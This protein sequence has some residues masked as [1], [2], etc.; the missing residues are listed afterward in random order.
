MSSTRA[1]AF[2]SSQCLSILG[3][4]LSG[5]AIPWLLLEQDPSAA[6]ASMVLSFQ[7]LAALMTMFVGSLL[8]DR[9]DKRRFCMFSDATLSLA[10]AII[11]G[12]YVAKLLTPLAIVFFVVLHAV[13]RSLAH[14]AET[15]LIPQ[16]ASTSG[17]SNHRINGLIGVFHN[18][19]DLLGPAL[20]GLIIT[21]IGL[22]GALALDSA[23][24]LISLLLF[25][26]CIPASKLASPIAENP[27]TPENLQSQLFGGIKQIL[28][29]PLLRCVTIASAIINM[30]LT[31]LLSVLILVLVKTRSGS[32]LDAGLLLSCF[33]IGGFIASALFAWAGAK[34]APLPAMAA[35]LILMLAA[36]FTLPLLPAHFVLPCLFVIGLCV[37]YLGPL[38]Q[39]MVQNHTQEALLGRVL[40]AYSAA[41]TVFVPVGF[42]LTAALLPHY[43]VQ[44]VCWAMAALLLYPALNVVWFV[45]GKREK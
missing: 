15:A 14:A 21:S 27:P 9:F 18:S 2:L 33:G 39:T 22:A 41:R 6:T 10:L 43:G 19:G 26:W 8:I 16:I 3:S 37:G 44:G 29:D 28:H 20:G 30:V 38:E 12:L 42:F 4:A 11:V 23:S 5:I 1:Y 31:P 35:S 45:V 13:M 24:F 7:A 17:L 25:W 32:A 40:L 34:L 36:F